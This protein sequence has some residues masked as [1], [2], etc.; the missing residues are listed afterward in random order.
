MTTPN[1]SELTLEQQALRR[2]SVRNALASSQLSGGRPTP[3]IIANLEAYAQG[4]VTIEALLEA[5]QSRHRRT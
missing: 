4:Q 1:P 3:E 5:A 2:T